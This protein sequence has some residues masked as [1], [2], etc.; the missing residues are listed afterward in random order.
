M[1]VGSRR[2]GKLGLQIRTLRNDQ[3]MTIRELAWAIGTRAESL[4]QIEEGHEQVSAVL[5]WEI[6]TALKIP[7]SRLFENVSHR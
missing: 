4:E 6:A 2:N 5:L 7:L 1:H 3:G